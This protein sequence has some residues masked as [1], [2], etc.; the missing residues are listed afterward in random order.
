[1]YLN[2]MKLRNVVNLKYI[3][4]LLSMK[5]NFTD[6][7]AHGFKKHNDL[8]DVTSLKIPLL[9]FIYF[10]FFESEKVSEDFVK[11]NSEGSLSLEKR[12]LRD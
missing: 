1:M 4:E 3:L 5:D 11:F 6:G 9:K 12:L 8:D 7:E 10:T 2:E